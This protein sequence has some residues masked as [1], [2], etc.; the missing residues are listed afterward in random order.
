M[1]KVSTRHSKQNFSNLVVMVMVIHMVKVMV[2][3]V[4]D[5]NKHKDTLKADVILEGNM[6]DVTTIGFAV[7]NLTTLMQK[8]MPI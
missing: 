8:V 7:N 2:M 5:P 4:D 3:V 1:K 6:V